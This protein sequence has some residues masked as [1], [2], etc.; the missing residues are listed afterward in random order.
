MLRLNPY[1]VN[2]VN[3]AGF[4]QGGSNF[5]H[6]ILRILEE[7]QGRECANRSYFSVGEQVAVDPVIQSPFLT[8]ISLFSSNLP[9][10][11]YA[12][13]AAVEEEAITRTLEEQ[14]GQKE[15]RLLTSLAALTFLSRLFTSDHRPKPNR[16]F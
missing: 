4:C 2:T 1:E 7:Q 16:V 3:P 15:R 11:L 6:A 9:L 12:N 10:T 14:R 5:A 8:L 13:H